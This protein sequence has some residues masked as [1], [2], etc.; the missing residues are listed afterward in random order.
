MGA[1]K[2]TRGSTSNVPLPCY[3]CVQNIFPDANLSQLEKR[4]HMADS[5][6]YFCW[7]YS[8]FQ[9]IQQCHEADAD[10]LPGTWKKL[11]L[12]AVGGTE[13]QELRAAKL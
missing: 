5:A 1:N 10:M 2:R 7:K 3:F 13:I 8:M 9:H 12:Y 4:F 6:S 11:Q